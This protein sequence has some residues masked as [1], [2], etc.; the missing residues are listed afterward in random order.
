M[1]EKVSHKGRESSGRCI[2]VYMNYVDSTCCSCGFS[3][4][5]GSLFS[6]PSP[7]AKE[8][9]NMDEADN[10]VTTWQCSCEKPINLFFF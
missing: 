9:N 1:E 5:K 2:D 10:T 8:C 3:A 4:V 6:Y 7:Y